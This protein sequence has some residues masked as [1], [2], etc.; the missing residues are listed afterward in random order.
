MSRELGIPG[1]AVTFL[2][3]LLA[4]CARDQSFGFGVCLGAA[5]WVVEIPNLE[6]LYPIRSN[7]TEGRRFFADR[8]G[9]G[10][11]RIQKDRFGV[12]GLEDDLFASGM[13]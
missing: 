6:I 10:C 2:Q 8:P 13:G 11:S 5:P 4:E 3:L 12:S 9:G 1:L 7:P